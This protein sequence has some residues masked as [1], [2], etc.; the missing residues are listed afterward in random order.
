MRYNK[1]KDAAETVL[2]ETVS[3]INSSRSSPE[4]VAYENKST[5]E[6]SP[7]LQ[8]ASVGFGNLNNHTNS[9]HEDSVGFENFRKSLFQVDDKMI[10]TQH[11]LSDTVEINTEVNLN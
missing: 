3:H 11:D 2:P 10:L 7:Y 6:N 9:L 8:E 4:T 1:F 5:R